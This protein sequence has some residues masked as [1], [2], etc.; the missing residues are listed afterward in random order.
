M[1]KRALAGGVLEMVNR[2]PL[3][4]RCGVAFLAV[5]L[6][7]LLPLADCESPDPIWIPGIYDGGDLDDLI[8]A[9]TS[10]ILSPPVAVALAHERAPRT[11][12]L[13]A[14]HDVGDI[15]DPGYPPVGLRAPPL[16]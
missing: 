11:N 3:A 16:R 9:N 12:W 2:L 14:S 13:V 15:A 5:S 1:G 10:S 8:L 4:R 7:A 6:L